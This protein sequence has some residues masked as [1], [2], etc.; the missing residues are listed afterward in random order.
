[1]TD[2]R[3]SSELVGGRAH[4][5]LHGELDLSTVDVAQTALDALEREAGAATVVLDLRGL[6]FM[7][8][9]GLHFV[10]R[11]D[12]RVRDRGGRLVIVRGR[13]RVDRLFRLALLDQRLELLED[14]NDL[15]DPES[16]GA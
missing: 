13:D 5:T 3:V 12:A 15:G 11:A 4:L 9:T 14:L 8:S 10:L 7:D 2:L 1:V 6:G 16:T